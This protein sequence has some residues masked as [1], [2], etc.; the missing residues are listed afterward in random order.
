MI[1]LSKKSTMIALTAT[2]FLTGCD[3][4][5]SKEP[6]KGTREPLFLPLTEESGTPKTLKSHKI[7]I[8]IGKG[9]NLKDWPVQGGRHDN[10]LPPLQLSTSPQKLWRT[11]IGHG[12]NTNKKYTANMVIADNIIFAMDTSGK[13]SAVDAKDGHVLWTIATSPSDRDQDTLGGG[14]GYEKG[15]VYV[16]T[17]FGEVIALQAAD[18][19]EIWRQTSL[20]TPMRV[21][22]TIKDGRVFVVNI[23]NELHAL[24]SKNGEI[25]WSHAGI[26]ETTSLLGGATPA[27]TNNVIIIPYS[28]GEVHALRVEN[29]YPLWSES[30]PPSQAGDSLSGI[31]HIRARPLIV[32]GAAYIVSH[33]GRMVAI[34]TN[35]GMRI[36]Q[37]DITGIRTPAVFGN[38]L[39]IISNTQ[40]VTC[41]DRQ[42]G[43]SVWSVPLPQR[44]SSKNVNHWAGPVIAGGHLVLTGTSGEIIYLSPNTGEKM[45]TVNANEPLFLS[46]V[47]C[48]GI[49]Y[50]LS[51]DGN[52]IAWK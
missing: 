5:S 49:L 25:L 29:G 42:T 43:E 32:D 36:W 30:I 1:K 2:T 27:L 19:K 48:D 23:S 46:P 37:N 22:P 17:S 44:D 3:T 34:D 11:N 26:P 6:L 52:I 39:F 13:V 8:T 40:E 35:T 16:A 15:T 38:Y 21:A 7:N 28:S 47:I 31:P 33:G 9:E 12:M 51:N 4:F 24:N 18:G 20:M 50:T 41:I 45:H 14:V 10:A